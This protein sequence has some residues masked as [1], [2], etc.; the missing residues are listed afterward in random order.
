VVEA[1]APLA[2]LR[3]ST[4]SSEGD[5]GAA[6]VEGLGAEAA[7][8]EARVRAQQAKLSG[9]VIQLEARRSALTRELAESR[10][11]IAMQEERVRLAQTEVARA[12][13]VAA[14]GFLP[15][16]ELDARRSAGL[17][18]ENDLSAL[19][20]SALQLEREIGEV[21]ARARQA[22]ADAQALAAEAASARASFFQR[23]TETA[24]RGSYVVTAAVRGRVAAI[25]VQRGQN[26]TPGAAVAVLT[27]EG[28]RLE[29]ELYTPSR[30]AGFVRVGQE[31][32]LMYQAFPH[33][34]FGTGRGVVTSVSR[35]VLAPS[36]VSL[37]GIQVQEPVFRVRVRLARESVD[38]YG[39]A[40][41]LQPGMLLTADV[42]IDRRTLVE[43]LLD[44]LYAAGRRS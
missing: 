19:R 5:V 29:A 39:E 26:L 33:Q 27:P 9:E 31:V 40:L 3:L 13:E 32:R 37:P 25:P 34:K 20:S 14:K 38:A 22:P 23:R 21:E 35:T 28:S 30:S 43:W 2:V 7:A 10:R 16:R 17:A 4:D 42:V 1:G 41:A 6:L 15:R 18:A 44:P 8:A 36:E 11:R 12:E 24:A